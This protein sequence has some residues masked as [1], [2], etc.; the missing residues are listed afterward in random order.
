MCDWLCMYKAEIVCSCI[1]VSISTV[2]MHVERELIFSNFH[3]VVDLASFAR[4]NETSGKNTL[5]RNNIHSTRSVVPKNTAFLCLHQYMYTL[6]SCGSLFLGQIW[7]SE[8]MIKDIPG[9]TTHLFCISKTVL[10]HV[11]FSVFKMVKCHLREIR[12]RFVANH[13]S[14]LRFSRW[15][16]VIAVELFWCSRPVMERNSAVTIPYFFPGSV[17]M[18]TFII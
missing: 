11:S 15:F 10:S 7:S 17:S 9:L 3:C 18:T 8:P 6:C 13:V 2:C 4:H 5:D 1:S 16:C 14:M 12:M